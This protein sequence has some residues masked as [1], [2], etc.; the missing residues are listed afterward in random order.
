MAFTFPCSIKGRRNAITFEETGIRAAITAT[1]T[2]FFYL[3]A[4]LSAHLW[5]VAGFHH[6]KIHTGTW[7]WDY[8]QISNCHHCI[9]IK[10]QC[11]CITPL[12]FPD[13]SEAQ[14]TVWLWLS[15]QNFLRVV[16][17]SLASQTCP[18]AN[19]R[20]HLCPMSQVPSRESSYLMISVTG[21]KSGS[22]LTLSKIQCS[23]N[24]HG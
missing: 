1:C 15:V 23:M 9:E 11:C 24:V 7:M 14:V 19:R 8:L 17:F 12:G 22:T 18:W 4:L 10:A 13:L 21:T 16:R 5:S 2:V 3:M 6:S 20:H